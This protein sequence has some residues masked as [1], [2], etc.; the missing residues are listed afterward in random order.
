[1]SLIM[2]NLRNWLSKTARSTQDAPSAR[3]AR[4]SAKVVFNTSMTGYK[5]VLTD[6]RT[7]ADL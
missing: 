5:E 2:D 1:M 6:R 4:P 3:P 7:R